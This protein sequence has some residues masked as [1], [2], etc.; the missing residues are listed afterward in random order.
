M[1]PNLGSD[2]KIVIWDLLSA[3]EN[4]SAKF[5]DSCLYEIIMMNHRDIQFRILMP[6]RWVNIP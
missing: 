1:F 3:F 4:L 6:Y 2:T 5:M